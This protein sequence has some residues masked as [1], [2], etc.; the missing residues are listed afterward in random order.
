MDNVTHSIAGLLLAESAVQFRAR[1]TG[2]EPSARFSAFAAVSA[3]VASNLPDAD[4]F[5]TGVGGDRLAYMLHHRGYTHT[6]VIAILGVALAWGVALL[7]WRWRARAAAAG[8][9]ANWLLGLIAVSVLGHLVLDWANSYGVHPFWP[10]DDRWLYGDAVFIV[11]PWFWVVAIPTLV[12]ASRGRVA[13]VL[14]S[15]V[16]LA[17]LALAWRVELVS[18]GAATVLTVGA[19]LSIV[20]ARV[21][22]RGRRVAVAAAGWIAVMLLMAAGAAVARD[23]AVR[24]V[25]ASDPMAELL[26]VVV[27]PMP[28]NPVCTSVI[29]VERAG[30]SYRVVRARVSGAPS[31]VD[32]SGCG[33]PDEGGAVFRPSSRRS[34][35]A[36]RWDTEWT[37]PRAELAAMARASCPVMAALRFI[38]VPI[39]HPVS[40]ST[41]M[42][43][44][45]RFGSASGNGFTDLL[46]PRRS[47]VCPDAVPPWT[48]P[49]LDLIGSTGLQGGA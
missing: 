41:I 30:E 20:L 33:I 36:V 3:L 16:L 27:T 35:P 37:A 19:V 29:T 25:R 4:L 32:A 38:R 13:R 49:R 21:L 5:Y 26:D 14:L 2:I 31:L 40:D 15:L 10:F 48:P 42:L 8:D 47:A 17:G 12:V 28:A 6:V 23:V 39:W 34:T 11:E 1:R 24:A 7:V 46:V 45:A 22:G 9:D 43:G 18:T 44:D